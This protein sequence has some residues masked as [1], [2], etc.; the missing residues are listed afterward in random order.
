MIIAL[1]CLLLS[2]NQE[3]TGGVGGYV[4][5]LPSGSAVRVLGIANAS[6]SFWAPNGGQ[7]DTH[8]QKRL[9]KGQISSEPQSTSKAL[10]IYF[11]IMSFHAQGSLDIRVVVSGVSSNSSMWHVRED[12]LDLFQKGPEPYDLYGYRFIGDPKRDETE[13]TIG[14]AEGSFNVVVRSMRMGNAFKSVL[15]PKHQVAVR[16]IE[17]RVSDQGKGRKSSPTFKLEGTLPYRY[18]EVYQSRLVLYK[19]NGT[20]VDFGSGSHDGSSG[21]LNMTYPGLAKEIERVELQRRP[22][23]WIRFEGIQLKPRSR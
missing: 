8:V 10:V 23:V 4:G 20:Q 5:I 11:D 21:N 1:S 18:S 15:G 7:L 3:P 2:L 22:F 13:L 14:L 16:Q 12:L 17:P 19:K 9:S 6:G